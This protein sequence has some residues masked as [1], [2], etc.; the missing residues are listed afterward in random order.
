MSEGETKLSNEVVEPMT[1]DG[2]A[3]NQ[4]PAETKP[5]SDEAAKP[6]DVKI[7]AC[8]ACCLVGA[9]CV[10]ISLK[11]A[12]R[13]PAISSRHKFQTNTLFSK[14]REMM[15][16]SSFLTPERMSEARCSIRKFYKRPFLSF[17]KPIMSEEAPPAPPAEPTTTTPVEAPVETTTTATE[18]PA[19]VVI[20]EAPKEGGA[21]EEPVI[22]P[23]DVPAV[24][25][26]A[27]CAACTLF[28]VCLPCEILGFVV[29]CLCL[30]FKCARLCCCPPEEKAPTPE[31]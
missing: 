3:E 22:T 31:A 7:A 26:C 12:S 8:Y 28:V 6:E 1:K 18:A 19:P 14:N 16:N 15:E 30:P 13:P 9:T 21:S 23:E 2:G 20:E 24:L 25:C 11:M 4:A 17:N 10:D 27:C 5:V 29:R